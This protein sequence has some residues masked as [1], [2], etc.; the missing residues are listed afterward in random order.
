MIKL[1]NTSFDCCIKCTVCTV[2]CPV[3]RASASYPGPK[4]SGPDAE[5]LRIK[6]PFLAD[7][8]LAYC[9][10]CKRCETVCPSDVRITDFI[11]QAKSSRLTQKHRIR[12]FLLTRTDLTGQI[13]TRVHALANRI[14]QMPATRLVLSVIFGISRKADFPRFDRST[15]ARS[16]HRQVTYQQTFPETVLYFHGCYVNY[17][18]HALGNDVVF[19]LNALGIGVIAPPQKCCGVPLIASGNLKKVK[20]N[21]HYIVTKLLNAAGAGGRTIIF[22]SSS[23]ILTVKH[24]YPGILQIDNSSVYHQLEFIT[25]FIH[26]R[27]RQKG[28]PEMAGVNLTAAYHAPCHLER[29]GGVIHTVSALKSIP[30]LRLVL[31]HSECCGIAGTYGFKKEFNGIATDIGQGLFDQINNVKPDIVITDCETCKMQIQTHTPYPVMHPVSVIAMALRTA[32]V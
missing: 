17:Y 7:Q 11:Y 15:F 28:L 6:T 25:A 19:V 16:L 26:K 23:C 4:Y 14:M 2:Y 9:N 12:D 30:G 24:D 8:S 3:A 10:N 32:S 18:D 27:F 1:E 21:G 29:T 5:R 20:K 22:S 31:L 13:A